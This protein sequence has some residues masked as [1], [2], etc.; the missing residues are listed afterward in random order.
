MEQTG[1]FM[2]Q[3]WGPLAI[4]WVFSF[5]LLGAIAWLLVRWIADIRTHR[6]QTERLANAYHQVVKENTETTSRFHTLL[7]ERTRHRR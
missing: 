2:L 7:D 4:G 3:T 5:V 1:I 6:E